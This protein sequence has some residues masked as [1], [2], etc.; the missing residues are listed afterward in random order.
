MENWLAR[1]ERAQFQRLRF[2][3]P[4]RI[5]SRISADTSFRECLRVEDKLRSKGCFDY[6][7]TFASLGHG[8]A[9]HDKK[10]YAHYENV[11]LVR[12]CGA[13]GGDE[14]FVNGEF[15]LRFF[16]VPGSLKGCTE[17]VMNFRVLGHEA[18]RRPQ[19]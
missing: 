2:A 13:L 3:S 6:A 11:L 7:A 1:L 12:F 8:S 5:F 18:F 16:F 17:R 4:T 14:L 9:Q 10:S 19:R 15:L